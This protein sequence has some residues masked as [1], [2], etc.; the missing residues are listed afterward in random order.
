MEY[1]L[2]LFVINGN[3]VPVREV[4]F[5]TESQCER[6]ALRVLKDNKGKL[7]QVYCAKEIK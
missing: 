2:I 7:N 6:Q 4:P 3:I 5:K 1:I